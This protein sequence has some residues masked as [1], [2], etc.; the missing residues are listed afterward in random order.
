MFY[1]HRVGEYVINEPDDIYSNLYESYNMMDEFIPFPGFT[2][3]G[4]TNSFQ[5]GKGPKE[6]VKTTAQTNM[7][8][9]DYYEL[10]GLRFERWY[11]CDIKYG[12]LKHKQYDYKKKSKDGMTG[13]NYPCFREWYEAGYTC[14][15]D[16]FDFMMELHYAKT[17]KGFDPDNTN[18]E[19]Q[20]SAKKWDTPDENSRTYTY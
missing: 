13:N 19:L 6:R 18:V 7:S 4:R 3:T 10:C 12:H 15:D 5:F 2:P 17:L 11:K 1:D 16:L 14:N 8:K 20:W 9:I